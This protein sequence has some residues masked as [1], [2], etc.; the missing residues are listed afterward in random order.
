MIFDLADYFFGA[1]KM[2][3]Y[4]LF[5]FGKL[6]YHIY[7]KYS[8]SLQLRIR[9]KGRLVIGKGAVLRAGTKIRIHDSGKVTLADGVGLNYY[10]L[11]NSHCSI[12]IGEGT[13]L[14]Q[15]VKLYDHDHIY[16]TE[17]ARSDTGFSTEPIVIGKNVWIGSDCI[18]LKGAV[19][20]DNSV[21]AAGSVIRGNVPENSVVYNRREEVIKPIEYIKADPE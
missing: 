9:K 18:I 1:L 13:I 17:G 14:G 8:R 20:G 11:I 4:K 7:G 21:V 6:K 16:K 19:I 12:S 15:G 3:I 10:C 5:Y 2:I